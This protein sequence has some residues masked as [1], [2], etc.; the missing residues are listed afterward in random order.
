[1][2]PRNHPDRIKSPSTII[3]WWQTPGCSFRPLAQHLGLGELVDNHVDPGD[4]PGRANTGDKV[5]TLVRLHWPWVVLTT[6]FG[7]VAYRTASRRLH[8]QG[9]IHGDL[10]AASGG[11][12]CPGEPGAAVAGL[13]GA[14]HVTGRWTWTPPSAKPT[15]G[16]PATTATPASGAI[17]CWPSPPEPVTWTRGSRQHR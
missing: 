8:A 17:R 1:M 3:G 14:P 6:L 4:A 10:P 11:G 5:M 9:A 7:R 15:T 16:V 2:L 12:T 13:A